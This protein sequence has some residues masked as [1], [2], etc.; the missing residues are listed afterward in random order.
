MIT[1]HSPF[2]PPLDSIALLWEYL[3]QVRHDE[4]SFHQLD[5]AIGA[6]AADEPPVP[7]A[8]D[9]WIDRCRRTVMEVVR[10]LCEENAELDWDWY[11]IS[12]GD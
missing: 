6:T 4:V 1:R 2:V 12:S 8:R 10:E 7:M 5:G 3:G 9:E 11:A